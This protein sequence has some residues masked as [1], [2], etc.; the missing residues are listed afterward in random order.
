MKH[1]AVIGAAVIGAGEI[2]KEAIYR[3]A[4]SV[5]A[6]LNLL[7]EEDKSYIDFNE[8]I[9]YALSSIPYMN[10]GKQFI[11]KGKH[12]YRLE[13]KEWICQCTRKIND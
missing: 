3:A 2:G 6:L 1:I 9:L 8:P 12:Q 10:E 11:C 5:P 7:E 4:L 13:G